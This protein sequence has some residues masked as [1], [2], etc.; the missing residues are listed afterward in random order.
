MIL[1][2]ESCFYDEFKGEESLFVK[3][4]FIIIVLL[5]YEKVT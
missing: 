3:F 5:F 4:V 1:M 2:I